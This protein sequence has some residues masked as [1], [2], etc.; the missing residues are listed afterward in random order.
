MKRGL[1]LTLPSLKPSEGP[2][3]IGRA[4]EGVVVAGRRLRPGRAAEVAVRGRVVELQVE[5]LSFRRPLHLFAGDPGEDVGLVQAGL[6]VERREGAA[7]VVARAVFARFPAAGVPER[8]VQ[9][10]VVVERV[11]VVVVVG[12][13]LEDRVPGAPARRH[14]FAVVERFVAVAVEELADVDRAVA[15]A[16]QPGGDVVG[17]G[18][19][20]AEAGVAA[21][22]GHVAA[23]VVVVRV[24]TGQQA[25]P[26]RAAERVGD[27]VAV[28]GRCPL[29]RSGTGCWASPGS[30][31]RRAACRSRRAGPASGRRS[32]SRR[33]SASGLPAAARLALLRGAR[34]GAA[35]LALCCPAAKTRAA[36]SASTLAASAA[37]QPGRRAQGTHWVLGCSYLFI[38]N[39]WGPPGSKPA[40]VAGVAPER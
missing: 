12:V 1:S 39:T 34:R 13:G 19:A 22:R 7:E 9:H 2:C 36:S 32:G 23:D 33:S 20:E 15:R 30:A 29:R 8:P 10:A 31:S 17:V 25:D 5:G 27:V 3:G 6:A 26:R 40:P 4:G 37:A 16:L 38:G 11:A 28:E 14:R 21:V 35:A 18:L 24:A